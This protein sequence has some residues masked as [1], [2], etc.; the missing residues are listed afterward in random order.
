VAGWATRPSASVPRAAADRRGGGGGGPGARP[1]D[2]DRN[3]VPSKAA[4][5]I[6]TDDSSTPVLVVPT[7]EELEI[8]RQTAAAL[9]A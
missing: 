2:P 7:N 6:S 9:A 1:V 5:R 8:A 4:R 3:E